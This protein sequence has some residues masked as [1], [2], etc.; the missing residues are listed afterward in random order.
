MKLFPVKGGV[1][2][3]YRKEFTSEKAITPF[4][5][6]ALLFIPL[7]QHVGA[8]A[9]PVVE[10]GDAVLKG[11]MIARAQGAVSAPLH[12]PTSGRV[13]EIANLT[14]PHPS[15]LPQ[16]TIVIEADGKEQWADLPEPPADPL[17][18]SPAEIARRVAEAGIV[19]LGGAT[20]PSAVKLD[21][22]SRHSLDTLLVNGAE[23]EP[24][25]T[26]DDRLM[27]EHADEIMDGVRIMAYA[28][29]VQT[30]IIAIETNKPQ[31]L[32]AMT[33]AAAAD[34][35][36]KVVG[37]PVRYPMGSER[38]LTL[39]LTGR[40]TPARR[41][42]A[43]IGVVVHN[44]ATTRA[45]SQALRS[46]RP[47]IS[48]LVTVSGSAVREP[49]NLEVPLGAK[50]A[51]LIEFCGGLIEQPRRIISGG[52]MMG[53]PLPSTDVPV[54]KGTSGVLALTIAETNEKA[55]LPCIRC[56]T[57][58][59]SCPCGLVPV[60][61][62]AFIRKENLD[63]AQA[64]GIMDCVSCGSCSYVCPSH[65]PLVHFFNYAKGRINALERDKRKR[66][67]VKELVE[68]R[69]ARLEKAAQAKR[70]ALAARKAAAAAAAAQKK[71]EEEAAA[72]SEASDKASA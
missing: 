70:E 46:G 8:P 62:A 72:A 1:H 35:D 25:L 61:M 19:G 63:G 57:C 55:A 31:A 4:P 36:I 20:F 60:E 40:E 24:Y 64:A 27:R 23:C 9:E 71:A 33:R 58:V 50:V 10:V 34:P 26:C 69:T 28:L 32:A 66:D 56:G 30:T 59:T 3:D 39:A 18:L 48:R 17:T 52:P 11:Q 68:R 21:L 13:V 38:H 49:K 2:P 44:V 15:G 16:R 42:T 45:V 53:Q 37:V 43:D 47:L 12:A 5:M 51:D 65:I 14:A 29:E 54:V 41:L 22:K 7:Q 67:L 6:P